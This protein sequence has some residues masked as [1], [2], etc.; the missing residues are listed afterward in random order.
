MTKMQQRLRTTLAA[1]VI[2]VAAAPL[3]AW[4]HQPPGA[5]GGQY[6]RGEHAEAPGAYGWHHAKPD[7]AAFQ[8]RVDER[9]SR[10]KTDLHLTADQQAPWATFESTIK[11]QVQAMVQRIEQRKASYREH[12]G[13]GRKRLST[14]QRLDARV[15]ALQAR[16]DTLKSLAAATKTFYAQLNP[17][18]QTV[19]DL[20]APRPHHRRAFWHHG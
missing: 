5:W 9:L 12:R 4:A 20:E 8:R 10:L 18:Q 13:D 17:T 15:A 2:A 16:L 11:A 1:A 3:A 6:H 14:P 19:F 7:P